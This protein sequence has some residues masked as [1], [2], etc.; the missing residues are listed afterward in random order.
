MF[1][2]KAMQKA[3]EAAQQKAQASK[4]SAE[5]TR[6]SFD[7]AVQVVLALPYTE[8]AQTFVTQLERGGFVIARLKERK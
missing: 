3:L 5:L 2:Y 6:L 1:D 7:E 8:S 4:L